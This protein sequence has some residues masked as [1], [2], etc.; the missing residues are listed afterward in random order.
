MKK[1]IYVALASVLICCSCAK[2]LL[3]KQPLD[4]ISDAVVWQD[5]VLID[6]Y[7]TNTY[8][9]MPILMNECPYTRQQNFAAGEI[10]NGPFIINEIADEAKRNWI[11]GQGNNA[12]TGGI[13]ISGGVLE[14]WENA[15]TVIRS[16]NEFIER[17]PGSPVDEDFRT[18]RIAEARFLRAYNYFAMVKR[19]G[20]VPLITTVQQLDAPEDELYPARDKE[21]AVYDFIIAEMDA[22]AD[23]LPVK[24]SS[25]YEYGRPTRHTAWALKC[26]AALYAGSI[27]QY[28]TVQLNGVV[29][30]EA[31]AAHYYEIAYD[32]A[33]HI[34]HSGVYG[35]YN[36]DADK[37]TNFKNIFLVEDNEEV[38][39]ARRHDGVNR[40]AG[41]NGWVYDFFQCPKPQ[42]WN[43]GNQNA[44]YLEMAEAFEY[45]D[46]TPGMLDR[47]AIQSGLWSMEDL[48]GGRDPRFYATIYTQNTPWQGTL[49]DFHNG[50]RLPDGSIL[51]DGSYQ[52]VVAK[53]TQ[54]TDGSYGTGFG[55]MKYLDESHSNMGATATSGTDW[56]LFR[57]AEVL[58]NYAEA[59]VEL[60][61]IP[62]A[63]DAINQIR[64]RA[65][66]TALT[67][68]DREKV[69]HERKIEL[70]FEG[71]RY[72]DVRRWRIAEDVLTVNR[73]GLR[74]IL[75][76]ET[77]DYQLEVL[78]KIDG[79]NADPMFFTENYYLP[80]TVGRTG[81]N[82]NLVENPGY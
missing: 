2:D 47:E 27:A 52:G 59:A 21:Q 67:S 45:I 76:Y 4:M 26:R 20:G 44:P 48:W 15:Y 14:W 70:A 17:L 3:N 66:I 58:L 33:Q 10:W 7:L 34:M 5:Q 78:Q 60:E 79:S 50:L 64:A 39:W 43:A 35:L 74:Y 36:R 57:Y 55:V 73:S 29:G 32:A 53:G 9:Q 31:P 75:D 46:G 1:H 65:G 37:V 16:L 41:G 61:R 18:K 80:I 8:L 69:R 22:I 56:Q 13:R 62:D 40:E 25:G 71:H 23:D 24:G 30:I 28:G 51:P 38:M 12:K 63:L 42:A 11:Y 49:V 77:G 6:A 72:W 68:V 19:Y 81:N 54:Q 82:P